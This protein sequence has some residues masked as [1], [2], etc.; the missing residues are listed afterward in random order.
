MFIKMA[1][2]CTDQVCCVQEDITHNANPTNFWIFKFALALIR[3]L[4]CVDFTFKRYLAFFCFNKGEFNSMKLRMITV[5]AHLTLTRSFF[6]V[7]N[8]MR[9]HFCDNI[10]V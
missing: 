8:Q 3:K 1:F 6:F 7:A 9:K 4:D 2:Y 10:S 5:L